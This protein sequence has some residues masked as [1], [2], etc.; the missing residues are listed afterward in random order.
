MRSLIQVVSHALG[1]R[2]SLQEIRPLPILDNL[3]KEYA[4]ER[5]N[6]DEHQRL[7]DFIK[8]YTDKHGKY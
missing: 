8:R 3:A 5:T 4:L 6:T 7:R 1:G 2:S